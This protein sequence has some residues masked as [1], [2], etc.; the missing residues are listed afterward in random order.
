MPRKCSVDDEGSALCLHKRNI[1]QLLPVVQR[2]QP[3]KVWEGHHEELQESHQRSSP[4]SH[5]CLLMYTLVPHRTRPFR[6]HSRTEQPMSLKGVLLL[7][8]NQT[9]KAETNTSGD[10]HERRPTTRA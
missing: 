9:P 8:G 4:S 7:A 5:D 3:V 1:H 6:L 2:S 10:Q